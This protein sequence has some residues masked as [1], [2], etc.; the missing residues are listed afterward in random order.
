MRILLWARGKTILDFEGKK[1]RH[2]KRG[3]HVPGMYGMPQREEVEMVTSIVRL[4][5]FR[6][7]IASTQSFYLPILSQMGP[8]TWIHNQCLIPLVGLVT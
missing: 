1:C 8:G 6:E 2:L 3:T 7:G 5:C 4:Q